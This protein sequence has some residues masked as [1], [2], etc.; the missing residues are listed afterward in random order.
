MGLFEPKEIR[1]YE[2]LSFRI[3]GVAP[4]LMR[5]GRL[6]DPLDEFAKAMKELTGKRKKTD[7]D[8]MEIGRIEFLGGL[9]TDDDGHPGIP[10][11]NIEGMFNHAAGA[12]KLKQQV[13]SGLMSNGFWKMKY[14]GPKSPDVLWKDKRFVDRRGV[15]VMSSRVI[16]TRPIFRKWELEFDVDYAPEMISKNNVMML[17]EHAGRFCG[18][19]D[20]T[21][22][23]GRFELS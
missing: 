19:C 4:L 21:P 18:L 5:N 7:A 13:Q 11:E 17:A 1:M 23:F 6:A 12:H 2:R 9:Y 14:E 20:H 3:K 15:G 8:H 10:G 16:R 22:K